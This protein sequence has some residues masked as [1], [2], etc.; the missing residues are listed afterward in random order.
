MT[1]PALKTCL[2]CGQEDQDWFVVGDGCGYVECLRCGTSTYTHEE[3]N[4]AW[5]HREIARLKELCDD[6]DD[7]LEHYLCLKERCEKAGVPTNYGGGRQM[8]YVLYYPVAWD[9]GTPVFIQAHN[10]EEA[11]QKASM[12]L[13]AYVAEVPY[14]RGGSE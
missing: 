7:L 2:V 5:G 4:N 8:T 3:W 1:Q 9:D 6:L 13:K 12:E 10:N 11:A 14:F